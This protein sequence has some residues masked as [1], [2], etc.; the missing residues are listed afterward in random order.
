LILSINYIFYETSGG[1]LN[2]IGKI[3]IQKE[4]RN[5]FKDDFQKQVRY[6]DLSETDLNKESSINILNIGDSFSKQGVIGYQNYLS[7]YNLNIINIFTGLNNTDD[8]MQLVFSI[9]NGDILD[10]LNV[11]YIILETAERSFVRSGHKVDMNRIMMAKDYNKTYV[12]KENLKEKKNELLDLGIFQDMTFYFFWNIFYNFDERAYTSKVCKV[13]LT[14]KLFSTKKNELLFY[15][16]DI[17]DIKYNTRESV[18]G[19]NENLNILSKKLNEKGVKL[20]V[21]PAP[22]KYDLYYHFIEKNH[23]PKNNFFDYMKEEKK[24]YLYINSKDL[25]LKHI[26]NGAKDVYFADDT[27]WSPIASEIIAKTIYDKLN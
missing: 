3:S 21:L 18:R 25:L 26:N 8:P 17:D 24:E 23:F 16:D 6:R 19:L 12:R 4:Y 20:I 9:V 10:K 11:D 13:N 2:R 22:D 27:H 15:F 7:S 5:I 14:K 1:D